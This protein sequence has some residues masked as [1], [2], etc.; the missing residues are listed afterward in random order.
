MEVALDLPVPILCNICEWQVFSVPIS[1]C[2]LDNIKTHV[3]RTGQEYLDFRQGN[4][5]PVPGS[6]LLTGLLED[7]VG[8]GIIDQL[9]KNLGT[10]E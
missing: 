6:W 2:I 7:S 3:D 10:K 9:I 8:I 5:V 1:C 4:R